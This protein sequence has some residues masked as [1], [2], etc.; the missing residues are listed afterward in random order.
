M[1]DQ[2]PEEVVKDRFDRL[3][4][5]VQD[6]SARLCGRDVHTVQEVLAEEVNDHSPELITGRLSNNTIV[7]FPGDPSMIGQLLPVYL[8]ESRGF[9]YMGR[10]AEV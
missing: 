5:E 10:L 3:L 4:K 2:I 6:I 1:E 7:H 8:E 9:Y